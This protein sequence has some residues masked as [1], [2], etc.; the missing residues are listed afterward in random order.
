MPTLDDVMQKL[1]AMESRTENHLNLIHTCMAELLNPEPDA[2]PTLSA[3]QL[4]DELFA[5]PP[6]PEPVAPEPPGAA[7]R[8]RREET[9]ASAMQAVE[10]L[11]AFGEPLAAFEATMKQADEALAAALAPIN[12][13]ARAV[14]EEG[15]QKMAAFR[16]PFE[17]QRNAAIDATVPVAEEIEQEL[18][19]ALSQASLRYS[20]LRG[21]LSTINV[22]LMD[23]AMDFALM[24]Q[25]KD[26]AIP[27]EVRDAVAESSPIIKAI[28]AQAESAA[29]ERHRERRY[30]EVSVPRERADRAIHE[31]VDG[32]FREWIA[33]G[34]KRFAAKAAE[35]FPHY[36]R[37]SEAVIEA[38]RVFR[39]AVAAVETDGPVA[40]PSLA[41]AL[42]P[43]PTVEDVHAL[44]ERIAAARKLD[45]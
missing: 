16:A 5:T 43:G 31:A 18:R 24:D 29:R 26:Y 9:Q 41:P 15:N 14:E 33:D 38:L 21:N 19:E 32:E 22:A 34:S 8:R 27:K 10:D 28:K 1:Q 44:S 23:P 12:E 20:V 35:M 6:E 42:V 36:Q 13:R 17:A 39:S 40:D 3:N 30:R 7:T 2:E 4:V 25:A 45:P 37:Y 11:A